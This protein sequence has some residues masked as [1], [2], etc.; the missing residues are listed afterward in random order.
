MAIYLTRGKYS[1]QAFDGLMANPPRPLP[2][3]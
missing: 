3:S 1:N 2:N